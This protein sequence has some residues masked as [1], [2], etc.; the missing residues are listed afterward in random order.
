MLQDQREHGKKWE[1]HPYADFYR[2]TLPEPLGL[3]DLRKNDLIHHRIHPEGVVYRSLCLNSSTFA[4]SEIASRRWW[5]IEPLFPD[6]GLWARAFG[7]LD[8]WVEVFGLG[9]LRFLGIRI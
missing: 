3:R 2:M 5:C 6:L 1:M 4:V 7:F 8:F 9:G